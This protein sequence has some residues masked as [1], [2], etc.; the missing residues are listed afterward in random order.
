MAAYDFVTLDV[1]T[2]K[3]F[4]GNQLAVLLDAQGLSLE[5][6][7]TITREFNYAEST[8]VLPPE[9]PDNTARVRIFTPGYEMPFAGH[10]TVGTAIAVARAKGLKGKVR[11]ELN[12]GVFPVDVDVTETGGFAEFENPNLPTETGAAPSVD[13]LAAALSL[14]VSA[15][16]TQAHKP[17]RCGAGVDYIY[18]KASLDAV[19]QAKVNSA[20]WDDLALEEIVGIYLYAEGGEGPDVNY[21]ARMFAPGAGVVEDAATGSAAAGFPAQIIR[22]ETI[23]DGVHRWVIEQG[24]EMGRPSRINATVAVEGGAVQ[25]V[26]IGGDAVF[27]QEG[28]IFI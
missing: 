17:R 2:E 12:T 1:F 7:Q 16:E 18:V 11:L 22:S 25:S 3:K 6:M 20:V 10:P 9:N 21:H 15:I 24:F 13:K 5:Q 8:F 28:R 26:R 19:K 23:S 14:Q 27:M 4:T